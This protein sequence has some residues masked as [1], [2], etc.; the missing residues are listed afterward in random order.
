MRLSVPSVLTP[1]L[2]PWLW[3]TVFAVAG[4]RPASPSIQLI[5]LQ[6]TDIE[7][8]V[9]FYRDVFGWEV[10]LPDSAY[11]LL[12]AGPVPIGL[13][14]QDSVR[15]GGAMLVIV[16]EDL[17]LLRDR[18]VEYG[19]MLRQPIAPSWR[20]RQFRFSDLDGNDIVVWSDAI[21]QAVAPEP[22]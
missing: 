17:E 11:A 3:L 20:G 22:R 16:T 2:S 14:V 6:V 1:A 21:T 13:V 15:P 18:V 12:D 4:C 5:E 7:R 10:T 8:A 19:G 9:A